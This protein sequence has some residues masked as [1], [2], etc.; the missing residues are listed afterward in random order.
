MA[1]LAGI[2]VVGRPPTGSPAQWA[3][4]AYLGVV[5]MFLGFLAWY[6]GLAYGPMAQ[7]SQIQLVQPVLTLGWAALLLGENL[8]WSTALG[9]L[10]VIACA[11]SAV[12]TRLGY[13]ATDHGSGPARTD[14]IPLA[15]RNRAKTAE[16]AADNGSATQRQ[17]TPAARA[18]R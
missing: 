10:A 16:R 18:V 12:R 1:A 2:A 14:S 5:S 15:G 17:N 7:V 6:R 3:S 13:P 4:F 9:A 11:G 8:T